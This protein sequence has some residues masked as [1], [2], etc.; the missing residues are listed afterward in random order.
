MK[1]LTLKFLIESIQSATHG[2]KYPGFIRLN[3][4]HGEQV[5]A[6]MPQK[7]GGVVPASSM[8]IQGCR[9]VFSDEVI[10]DRLEVVNLR[11]L[12]SPVYSPTIPIE[13]ADVC[14]ACGQEITREGPHGYKLRG[15]EQ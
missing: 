2:D 1:R 12:K 4:C 5:A 14:P 7:P 9:V 8:T 6:L 3:P 11:Y 13:G 15:D 10:P